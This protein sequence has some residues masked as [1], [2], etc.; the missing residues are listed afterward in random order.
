M[1]DME[2]KTKKSPLC[3]LVVEDNELLQQIFLSTYKNAHVVR[4]ASTI[5]QAWEM[6]NRKPP[7][8]VFMDIALPDG[9][10]HDL[11]YRI[12]KARPETYIVMVTAST[13]TDDKEEAVFNHV[14]G[15]ITKPF[16]KAQIDGTIARY[17][18]TKAD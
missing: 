14:N 9:N 1:A 18:E 6:F 3:I 5:K 2:L 11:V 10:G 13:Y 12:K 16:G 15:F 7:D 4:T 8:I 17:W